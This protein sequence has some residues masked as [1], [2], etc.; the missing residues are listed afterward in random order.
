MK[1]YTQTLH[2]DVPPEAAFAAVVDPA[3]HSGRFMKVEVVT[4]TPDGVGTTLRYYYKALG[5]RL[6]GSTYTYSEYVPGKRFAW[7][8]SV[9]VPQMLLFG[10][11]VASRMTF[12]AANGGTDVVIHAA[13]RANA[14]VALPAGLAMAHAGAWFWQWLAAL[15][16]WH[17]GHAVRVAAVCQTRSLAQ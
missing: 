17:L 12:E 2:V 15:W 3:N 8:F 6:P 16:A 10:G 4:E 13:P 9:G 11:P 5:V 1:Q 14:D 7:D